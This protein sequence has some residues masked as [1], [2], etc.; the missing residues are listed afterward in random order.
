MFKTRNRLAVRNNKLVSSRTGER[1]GPVTAAANFEGAAEMQTA[2]TPG[3]FANMSGGSR[4]SIS[5]SAIGTGTTRNLDLLLSGFL[6]ERNEYGMR[7]IYRDMY[8]YDVICGGAADMT[9]TLPFS[10]FSLV[11]LED[12]KLQKFYDSVDRLNLKTVF[13]EFSLGYLVDGVYLG[14]LV[15]SN[16][17]KIFTDILPYDIQDCRFDEMPFSSQ[18]AVATVKQNE[19]LRNFL[20]SDDPVVKRQRANYSQKLLSE[21][22]NPEFTLDP[23]TT[24]YLPRRALN[25]KHNSY[26]R[27]AV[28]W[29]LIEKMLLRGTMVEVSKRQRSALHVAAGSETWEPTPD[30][31]VTLVNLFQQADFDPL[32]PIIATRNDVQ[33]NEIRQGGDF[34]KVTDVIDQ[35]NQLKLRALGISEDFLSGSATYSTAE[36][37]LSVYIENLRTYR[38]FLTQQVFYKKLFPIIAHVNGFTKDKSAEKASSLSFKINDSTKYEMPQVRWYK[39]LQPH[40]DR[41]TLDLLNQLADKGVPITLRMW[42]AAGGVDID[43]VMQELKEDK[44]LRTDIAKAT[45]AGL[46]GT[47]GGGEGDTDS[48]EFSSVRHPIKKVGFLNRDYSEHNEISAVDHSGKK[49]WVHNQHAAARKENEEILKALGS[50]K[51]PNRFQ[52]INAK[53]KLRLKVT[54]KGK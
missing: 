39:S 12:E 1:N 26:F 45:G 11:G 32:G 4:N 27:R 54:T 19:Q 13:P 51:D 49:K 28:P 29:F 37:A 43:N 17:M 48:F 40:S 24:I 3:G 44:T 10:D 20:T 21:L 6:D 15:Y 35:T 2:Y 30:E 18:E 22:N 50:L 46:P 25:R 9:S 36:A 53:A 38:D 41:D 33:T 23:M 8:Y 14:T 42:A 16:Q 47:E 31:L 5:V 52:E 34:L 7:T